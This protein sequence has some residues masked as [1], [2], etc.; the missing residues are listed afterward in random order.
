MNSDPRRLKIFKDVRSTGI[1]FC[2]ARVPNTDRVF[3][4]SSDFHIH[5]IDF[6]AE[7]P[8]SVSFPGDGHDSYVTGLVI[9]GDVLISGSYDGRLIW[10]DT[11]QKKQIRTVDAHSKWIRRVSIS[12]DGKLVASVADDMQCK[13]WD[14]KTGKLVRTLSDHKPMT[15][16]NYPSMLYAV[17]FSSDGKSLATGD[18]VGHVAIWETATGKKLGAVEA[19]GMYTWDPRQRRH[20]IGGIRSVAFSH[21]AKILV[22]G[23]I[24]KINNI[25][26]LDGPARTEVFDRSTS[27]RQHE[28]GDTK[29]KGLVEQILFHP[30]GKWFVTV[31][32]DHKGFITFYD[33]SGGKVLHQT[34]AQDH[35]HDA[36]FNETFDRLYTVHHSHVMAWNL[37][38]DTSKPVAARKPKR[39]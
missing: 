7:K 6:S 10:W 37:P 19:P 23:G 18:K 32:G 29:H 9:A 35:C 3:V 5:E 1:G 4:G 20:S 26:H 25:D 34:G 21:D 12:P 36:A 22:A 27:K 2:L 14:A 15:P 31:G 24:G 28:L 17:A 16:H 39:V 13:L 8:K 11:D 38:A 33:T 30:D